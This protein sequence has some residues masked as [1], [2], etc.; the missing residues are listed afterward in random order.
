MRKELGKWLMDIAKYITTAVVL[1]SIFG[2][3]QEK[4]VIYIGG[5]LAIVVTLLAGLWLV[6]EEKKKGE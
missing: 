4:W 2:D 3:V 1:S 5:S 6:R